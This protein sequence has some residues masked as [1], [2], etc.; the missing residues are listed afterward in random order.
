VNKSQSWFA[1][2]GLK[3]KGCVCQGH[4]NAAMAVGPRPP[5]ATQLSSGFIDGQRQPT[6]RRATSSGMVY[7]FQVTE[8]TSR[9]SSESLPQPSPRSA[10]QYNGDFHTFS[11]P[12]FQDEFQNSDPVLNLQ[13][14]FARTPTS[15]ALSGNG[16]FCWHAADPGAEV[17]IWRDGRIRWQLR[18]PPIVLPALGCPPQPVPLSSGAYRTL[19][20][21]TIPMWVDDAKRILALNAAWAVLGDRENSRRRYAPSR[22]RRCQGGGGA[23]CLAPGPG[24]TSVDQAGCGRLLGRRSSL[25]AQ[26]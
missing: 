13:D 7:K 12:D 16:G 22:G 15:L 18:S 20:K 17:E 24:V 11:A 5:S 2:H 9:D 4:T 6:Q 26:V 8:I 1:R 14:L 10:H 23:A 3:W 21:R 19:A 25:L